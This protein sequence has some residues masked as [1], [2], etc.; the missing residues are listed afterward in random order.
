[1]KRAV[2]VL[3]FGLMFVLGSTA[4]QAA[5]TIPLPVN[6]LASG[7]ELCP[8][9]I[10]KIAIFT[11]VFQGQIGNN[12]NAIG[13]VTVA[14]NHTDLPTDKVKPALIT[15]GAWQLQSFPKSFGGTVIGGYIFFVEEKLFEVQIYL[16]ANDGR[17]LFFDGYLDHHPTIPTVKGAFTPTSI[18]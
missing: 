11:G 14:L 5:P 17:T 18:P 13:V 9:F 10:C 1:M 15:Q 8:Q 16:K 12:P 7:I 2:S 6:G 3:V 4:V